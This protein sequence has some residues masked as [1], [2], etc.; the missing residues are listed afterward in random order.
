MRT[1]VSKKE[2]YQQ[3]VALYCIEAALYVIR[4]FEEMNEELNFGIGPE[5]FSN[6]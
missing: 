6:F 3:L 1:A 4:E 2:K 5:L